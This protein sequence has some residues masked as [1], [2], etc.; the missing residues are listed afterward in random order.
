MKKAIQKDL[1]GKYECNKCEYKQLGQMFVKFHIMNKHEGVTWDC[2]LFSLK[3]SSPYQ[4]K[5]KT[6]KNKAQW[7]SKRVD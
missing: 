6:F 2:K 3:A 7:H 5:K 4:F 1:D